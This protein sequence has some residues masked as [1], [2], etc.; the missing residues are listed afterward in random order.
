MLLPCHSLF[1]AFSCR[2]L[3]IIDSMHRR[4]PQGV[5]VMNAARVVSVSM[6]V[7]TMITILVY[8]YMRLSRRYLRSD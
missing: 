4:L 1:T 7:A 2:A 3:S 8:I 6:V 5:S